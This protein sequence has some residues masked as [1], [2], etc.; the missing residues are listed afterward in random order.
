QHDVL[1]ITTFEKAKGKLKQ[2]VYPVADLVVPVDNHP[3]H[4]VQDIKEQMARFSNNNAV[5][6]QAPTPYNTNGMPNRTPVSSMSSGNGVTSSIFGSSNPGV[7]GSNIQPQNGN[8]VT[9]S[10]GQT[11]ENVLIDTITNMVAPDTWS[12]VGGG[13]KIQY[14]PLGMALVINQTQEV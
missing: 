4:P 1:M 14:F 6:H 8:S 7:S 3:L 12:S 5:M 13:G 9:R 2:V 11:I 10:Q